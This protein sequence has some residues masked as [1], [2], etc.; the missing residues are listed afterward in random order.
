MES[1]RQ[2]YN[3][4]IHCIWYCIGE[5]RFEEKEK[6]L[7]N[8]LKKIFSDKNIMPIIF[9]YAKAIDEIE[10]DKMRKFILKDYPNNSFV[11]TM[12]ED[13]DADTG[14]R[15]A[16]GKE[17]LINATLKKCTEALESDTLT[18]MIKL[19]SKN[20]KENLIENNQNIK[21][22][23]LN[24]IRDD[25][26]QDFNKTLGDGDFIKY[27][28]DIFL[29][30]LNYFYDNKK[31]ITNNSMNLIFKSDFVSSVNK[32]YSSFK[33]NIKKKIKSNSEKKSKELIDIQAILEQKS[34]NMKV[35][36][37]RDLNEFQKTTEIFLKKSYYF[38]AQNYIINYLVNWKNDHF[39]NYISLINEQFSNIIQ[40]LLN[41]KENDSDC[42]LIK[43]KLEKCFKSK[44][45]A[46]SKIYNLDN[47]DID[48]ENQ[49]EQSFNSTSTKPFFETINFKEEKLK[50]P[51]INTNSFFFNKSI[52]EFNPIEITIINED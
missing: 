46:F 44:V 45:K 7:F 4:F 18:I 38:L 51:L 35:Y 6:S 3:E 9:V 1:G 36:N 29:K 39:I 33:E 31:I 49:A 42:T 50:N 37:R 14:V 16:F 25:F 21:E 34:G 17:E 32:I 41:L 47:T 48:I 19:I 8:S 11:I 15:K 23:I 27:I 12:A 20:I 10:A 24:K 26:I 52:I 13:Y 43:R 28:N 2:N 5:R 40:N 30:Y 22:K